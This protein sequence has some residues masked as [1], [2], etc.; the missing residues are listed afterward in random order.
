M[1]TYQV[2]PAPT[3]Q[4]LQCDSPVTG[5]LTGRNLIGL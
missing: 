2:S 1:T 5:V 4:I 3:Q